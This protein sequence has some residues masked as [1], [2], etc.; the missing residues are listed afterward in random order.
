MTEEPPQ[1]PVY[2]VTG[3]NWTAEIGLDEYNAQFGKETQI[4]EA[5]T[6][7]I[8]VFKMLR[9]DFRITMNAESRDENPKLGTTIL[10][11]LKGTNPESALVVL[12]HI[13]L[14]DMGLYKEAYAMEQTFKAQVEQMK[15]RQQDREARD[16]KLNEEMKGI[17]AAMKESSLRR[18]KTRKKKSSEDDVI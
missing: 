8:E 13:C 1:L 15:K 2:I 11:H 9:E 14:G 16:A 10:V 7:A 6:R 17:S 18:R 4:Q 3:A 5:A 12:T